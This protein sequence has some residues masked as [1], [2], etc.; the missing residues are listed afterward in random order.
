MCMFYTCTLAVCVLSERERRGG[1]GTHM[2]DPGYSVAKVV[3]V[4]MVL[5]GDGKQLH[6]Q[7]M[8]VIDPLDLLSTTV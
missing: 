7:S 2:L 8:V 6:Q 5:G 3:V 4:R 1:G